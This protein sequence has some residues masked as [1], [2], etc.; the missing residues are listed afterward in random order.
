MHYLG[1]SCQVPQMTT[2]V[3]SLRYYHGTGLEELT[4]TKKTHQDR[5]CPGSDLNCVPSKYKSEVLLL[6]HL[7]ITNV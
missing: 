1:A 5:Q 7:L 2:I 6:Y 3:I 4:K